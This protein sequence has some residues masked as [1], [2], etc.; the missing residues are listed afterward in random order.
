MIDKEAVKNLVTFQTFDHYLPPLTSKGRVRKANCPLHP[1][2]G[3]RQQI[4]ALAGRLLCGSA[5]RCG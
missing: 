1:A 5:L 3:K 2:Y 4:P